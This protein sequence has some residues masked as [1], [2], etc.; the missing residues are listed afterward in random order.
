MEKLQFGG[1][2]WEQ[3]RTDSVVGNDCASVVKVKK[4]QYLHKNLIDL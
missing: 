3:S 1:H 2:L 4:S